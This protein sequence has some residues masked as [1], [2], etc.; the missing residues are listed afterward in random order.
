MFKIFQILN[1]FFV[2]FLI[3][4]IPVSSNGILVFKHICNSTKTVNFYFFVNE[5]CSNEE[6]D[7]C[8]SEDLTAEKEDSCCEVS[9]NECEASNQDSPSKNLIKPND[10]CFDESYIFSLNADILNKDKITNI[11]LLSLI[12][13]NH[14]EKINSESDNL[15]L[16]ESRFLPFS[17]PTSKIISFIHTNSSEQVSDSHLS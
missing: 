4:L 9:Y 15:Y 13:I 17:P 8:C 10:C 14:S 5:K 7:S 12:F 16:S 11:L 6:E 3:L 1:K 2:L